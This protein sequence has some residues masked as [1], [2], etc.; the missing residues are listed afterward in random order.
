M[1]SK[2]MPERPP[3]S[4]PL[5]SVPVG[6]RGLAEEVDV[7]DALRVWSVFRRSGAPVLPLPQKHQVGPDQTV[8][9]GGEAAGE[10]WIEHADEP[11]ERVGVLGPEDFGVEHLQVLRGQDV[12]GAKVARVG[13]EVGE[14]RGI[15][16]GMIA[17]AG[18]GL[19]LEPRLLDAA[20][21]GGRQVDIHARMGRNCW[22]APGIESPSAGS[23]L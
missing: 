11:E 1:A 7:A 23:A 21:T 10:R 3:K 14:V 20:F 2:V 22:M 15:E 8:I 6:K 16:G 9:G 12:I 19:A 18:V 17:M 13:S 5:K 4:V